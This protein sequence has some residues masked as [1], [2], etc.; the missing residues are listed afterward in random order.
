MH[1]SM[2][3]TEARLEFFAT[4]P[5]GLEGLLNEELQNIGASATRET[6]AGVYF[7]ASL[8]LAYKV[9]LWSRLANRIL[10]PIAKYQLDSPE[11]L[12]QHASNEAW[13]QFLAPD[14]TLK[15]DF[16]GTNNVIR[17]T[18]FGAQT[19]KDGVV[20]RMRD[21]LGRRPSV[22]KSDP[23]LIV[24][25]RLAKGQVHISL[26]LSGE[27]LHRR[28]YRMM[29]GEAPLK[30]NIAAAILIRS[31]WG[32]IAPQGG[33]LIDPMCGAGTF[34]I[35]G[36]FISAN[37]A[38]GLLREKFGFERW[39]YF[40]NAQWQAIKQEAIDC[41][42]A[43][44]ARPWPEIRGYDIDPKALRAAQAN[45][46]A[47]GLTG[48]VRVLQ[49]PLADFKKPTHITLPSGLFV[50]NPPYG[51]RLGEQQKLRHDYQTLGQVAK[52]QLP[53]WRVAVFTGNSELSR[54]IRLRQSKKYKL[55]N[56]TIASE[57]L[58]FDISADVQA[59]TES[60]VDQRSDKKPIN[61]NEHLAMPDGVQ[62]I[63]NRL[64]K[65][66]KR[67][68]KWIRDNNVDC[69]RVYD[70]DMPEYAAAIDVYG[71]K[72]H[73]QEYAAPK[74]VDAGNA[75]KRF[76][77]IVQAVLA[78]FQVDHKDIYTK[79]RRRKRGKQQYEKLS[80]DHGGENNFFVVH[81]GRAKLLVNLRDYLDTGLF[82]D[83]R[84]LRTLIANQVS[85]KSFL[86]LFCYTASATVHAVLAG[87]TSTTSVDLSNTYLQWAGQNFA[88]N[89]IHPQRHKLVRSDCQNWL[90]ECRQGFD[91]ILL[92]PPSFS[93]SK[94]MEGVLDIQR[95]HVALVQRCME[96]LKPGGVVYFSTNLQ[97]F[98]MD[99]SA[100]IQYQL[101]DITGQTLDLD[102]QR[103][104]KIHQCWQIK[105]G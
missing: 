82:L 37:I 1:E 58:I 80:A 50:C 18:Q 98:K 44:L 8:A 36:A 70:A 71:E 52:Q 67:L 39:R 62:M 87:A 81:E 102:F 11:S 27:S 42:N 53:G 94:A 105:P 91:V 59:S 100:F 3:Q 54:E 16:L 69:Y 84:P 33:A 61:P 63:A 55:F 66:S 78:V 30:E 65:N 83:H 47:A 86:N 32:D 77:Q 21:K 60:S 68:E 4:C 23:D 103:N 28:G 90:K 104:Q 26:D 79:V 99:E 92:D 85:G 51:E 38:P 75:Q 7:N 5:K 9:C 88:L 97:S 41:K 17:N 25:A 49:K 29:Q 57:L 34:L 19:I 89:N 56:G 10:F 20:D 43:G 46:D 6:V 101:H 12:Y 24:N 95:D 74:T 22:S 40:D 2:R 15:V 31:G 76:N 45:I 72:I 73:I 93:N 48:K 96:L 13:E 14:A 64:R 35:E